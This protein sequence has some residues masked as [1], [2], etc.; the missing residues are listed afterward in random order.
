MKRN[1]SWEPDT[2]TVA[3]FE[4]YLETEPKIPGA[5]G[6]SVK[7]VLAMH[8]LMPQ[9]MRDED[10]LWILDVAAGNSR[11]TATYQ[12]TTESNEE[13]I[14]DALI[15]VYGQ[16][17]LRRIQTSKANSKRRDGKAEQTRALVEQHYWRL[18]E[19]YPKTSENGI[20]K[21]I[22]DETDISPR[23]IYRYKPRKKPRT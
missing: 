12:L 9:D 20:V 21:R 13:L 22:V 6:E 2:K 4:A 15:E 10:W 14:Q 7:R 11:P 5:F 18:K 1:S 19:K 3:A 23:Q 17:L 8:G 16:E